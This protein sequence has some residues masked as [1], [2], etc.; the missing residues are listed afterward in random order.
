[1]ADRST[2]LRATTVLVVAVVLMATSSVVPA[3]GQEPPGITLEASKNAIEFGA[4]VRLFGEISPPTEGET[5]SILDE[6]GNERA[7][8]TTDSSG[9]YSVVISPRATSNFHARWLAAI[10][11]PVQ[12]KVRPRVRVTLKKVRL[13][14]RARIT[15][16]VRPAQDS[17]RVS[18][19][20]F[21]SGRK[22]WKR[23]VRLRGGDSFRTSFLTKKPGTYRARAA[24]T[25]VHGAT[26]TDRST[27]RTTSLP[28]LASGSSGVHV[29]LL[30]RRLRKLGYHLDGSDTDYTERTADAVRA[31]N[32]IEGRTRLGTIGRDTWFALASATRPKPRYSTNGFHL[33][34]DQT[35]QVLMTVH[36]G[37][38]ERVIHVSTGR[39]GYTPDG[40][41]K[42][43]RKIAGYSG[44]GLYYPSYYEGRRAL[45]GWSEVP[46]Y[47]ASHGCTRLPMWTAQWVY[48]KAQ[49]GTTV[50]IYH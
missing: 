17:G 41:W 40:T 32:K 31:F 3:A 28:S 29:L 44:G 10:S 49:I 18:L 11:E 24:F 15:G 13:F 6:R 21:R 1:M 42:I 39:D 9:H 23:N 4:K 37:R 20:L 14:G 35:R 2:T 33:E 12:I 45:H 36:D 50:R 38:V 7:S 43:Y 22:M 16:S 19:K 48:G 46:T 25:D 34:I 5:I 47:N 30:E 26:G 8:T 27:R